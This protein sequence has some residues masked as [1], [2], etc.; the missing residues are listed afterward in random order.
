MSAPDCP[1]CG[2]RIGIM[3]EVGRLPVLVCQGDCGCRFS[4]EYPSEFGVPGGPICPICNKASFRAKPSEQKGRRGTLFVHQ[5][6]ADYEM[7]KG[8]QGGHFVPF[9]A[10][11]M[12]YDDFVIRRVA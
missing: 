12:N 6:S 4:T 11:P 2:G 10:D 9:E 5:C 7:G 3:K 8:I 1:H